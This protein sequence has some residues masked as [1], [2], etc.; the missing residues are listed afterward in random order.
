M[1]FVTPNKEEINP[2][3]QLLLLLFYAV[4]G[5]L[6]FGILAI[7]IVLLMYG[8]GIVSN[9]DM[10][11]AGDTRYIAGFKVIQILSSIGTFILPPIA[12]A[13]TE[14]KKVTEF[15]LFKQPKFLLVVLVLAIMILSMPFM[16]WTVIW[17]QKMI[18]PDF[19]HK[20]EQWMKE[21]EAIAM[22]MTIQLITVRSNFDFIVNLVMIAVIPAIGE[23]LMFRG[24]VQR[25]L[26]RAFDNPHIAIWLSAIIFSAIHVQ[27]YGFVPRMLLGAGFGYLYYYS[28]SIWY[29]MLAHF[30]NNAYAVCAAFY[31]QKHHMPLDKADEPIGFPWYGYLISAIITIALF[32][33]FKDNATRERKLG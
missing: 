28:G 3:L 32:K 20:I 30:L 14:R 8:L 6:V 12:L 7:V 17:N 4:I 16:E 33:I 15:Y 10:L 21:K 22:K 18:L 31:M 29:A 2:F 26:T 13:L 25:S 27:F 9:L 23:E 11:L 19:L 5:G 1:N 24:G